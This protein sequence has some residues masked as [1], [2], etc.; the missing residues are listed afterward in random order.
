MNVFVFLMF[1]LW[2]VVR[3]QGAVGYI[4]R[5][6]HGNYNQ[7]SNDGLFYFK[8]F[9]FTYRRREWRRSVFGYVRTWFRKSPPATQYCIDYG[10]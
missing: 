1:R 7:G 6:G 10:R 8:A 5:K 2:L 3:I 9:I 4:V